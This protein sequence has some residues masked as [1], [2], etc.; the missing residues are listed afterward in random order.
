MIIYGKNGRADMLAIAQK[1]GMVWALNPDTGADTTLN[2]DAGSLYSTQSLQVSLPRVQGPQNCCQDDDVGK[3]CYVS[4][5][6]QA[7]LA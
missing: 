5:G 6:I 4:W 7:A 3:R 1:S 2:P